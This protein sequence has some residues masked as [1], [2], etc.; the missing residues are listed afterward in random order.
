MFEMS[1]TKQLSVL[2]FVGMC[3]VVGFSSQPAN[4]FVQEDLDKLLDTGNCVGCDLSGA[5]LSGANLFDA[6]LGNTDLSGADLSG[7]DLRDAS[8]GNT[9]LSGADLSGADLS[10]TF[11]SGGTNFSNAN[12]SGANLS[13]AVF[14]NS[15]NFSSANLSDA[16]LSGATL[17]SSNLSSANLS[18]ADLSGAS[19]RFSSFNSADL[20]NADLSG[21]NLTVS[22]FNSADL[23]NADLRDA[24]FPGSDL[25]N[26]DLRNAD[27]SGTGI[28]ERKLSF[29]RDLQGITLD[30]GSTP[31]FCSGLETLTGS[32]DSFASQS[33][34]GFAQRGSDCN[35]LIEV[36]V[37][38]KITLDFD[39]FDIGGDFFSNS[40]FSIFDGMD[41]TA[42]LLAE[43]TGDIASPVMSTGNSLFINFNNGFDVEA[44]GF[45]ASFSS[46]AIEDPNTATTPEPSSLL[47]I[48]AL[49]SLGMMTKGV[50]AKR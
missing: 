24:S 18:G 22:S 40:T 14:V 3:A 35:F 4:A 33:G 5:D 30:D 13:K 50:A 21:A 1:L 29:A 7:A 12:L 34:F 16:N 15:S 8:L 17:E 27:F 37:G 46:S 11:S 49:G 43:F 38:N 32:S 6:N 2:G 25:D 36:A 20:S 31:S 26:A 42:D 41:E 45:E 28:N 9:D 23:R 48:L 39:V 19:F 47:T 10:D 44:P